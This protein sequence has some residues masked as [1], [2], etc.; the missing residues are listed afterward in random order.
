[1]YW[2]WNPAKHLGGLWAPECAASA[3]VALHQDV[4]A[5]NILIDMQNKTEC[6]SDS[7]SDAT[8]TP[9]PHSEPEKTN[10][11]SLNRRDSLFEDDPPASRIASPPSSPSTLAQ[12]GDAPETPYLT[13]FED[14]LIYVAHLRGDLE[15]CTWEL[16][17]DMR[18]EPR[19]EYHRLV[20]WRWDRR[21]HVLRDLKSN[22]GIV[23]DARRF[24]E[25][26]DRV[27][28]TLMP[29]HLERLRAQIGRGRRDALKCLG[30]RDEPAV[31]GLANGKVVG[32]REGY[33]RLEGHGKRKR[34]G[35][36]KSTTGEKKN[37]CKTKKR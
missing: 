20:F 12:D 13:R 6:E 15:W 22:R 5:A 14:A 10:I 26:P 29:A 21:V 36:R 17:R 27:L 11:K 31:E 2:N 18:K 7:D 24:L 32:K 8:M 1:M 4:E 25:S 30:I 23:R 9:S 35:K 34:Y 19:S 28:H 33:S 3:L 37:H 16:Y